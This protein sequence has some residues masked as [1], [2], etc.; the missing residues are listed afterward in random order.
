MAI[1]VFPQPKVQTEGQRRNQRALLS[2]LTDDEFRQIARVL[3]ISERDNEI[4]RDIGTHILLPLVA[5]RRLLPKVERQQLEAVRSAAS[6]LHDAL[7]TMLSSNSKAAVLLGLAIHPLTDW[8]DEDV[9]R[10]YGEEKVLGDW[11]LD[12]GFHVMDYSEGN[13]SQ[14]KA[15][16][17]HGVTMSFNHLLLHCKT[18]R[19]AAASTIADHFSDPRLMRGRPSDWQRD[20]IARA[21]A[22]MDQAFLRI[23]G[24]NPKKE[25]QIGSVLKRVTGNG[26]RQGRKTAA[27][28]R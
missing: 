27:K 10:H 22:V 13:S 18:L 23:A 4:R 9:V 5:R 12:L 19:E 26:T 21:A 3:K 6:K 16:D 1:S 14:E 2:I 28:G 17:A 24:R 25:A 15:D 20:D 11:Y 7:E 8:Q